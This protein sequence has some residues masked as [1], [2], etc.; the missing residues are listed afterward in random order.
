MPFMLKSPFLFSGAAEI[1]LPL[2]RNGSTLPSAQEPRAASGHRATSCDD[3]HSDQ[4]EAV[5]PSS[6]KAWLVRRD[7][8]VLVEG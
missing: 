5:I 1:C 6:E 3:S 2:I 8:S 4:E 7:Q